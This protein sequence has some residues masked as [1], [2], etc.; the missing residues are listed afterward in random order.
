MGTFKTLKLSAKCPQ[1]KLGP[2]SY[3]K[4]ETWDLTLVT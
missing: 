1:A 2:E 3:R 4:A